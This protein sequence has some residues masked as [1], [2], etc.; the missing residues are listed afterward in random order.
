MRISSQNGQVVSIFGVVATIAFVGS[1]VGPLLVPIQ[2]EFDVNFAALTAI[3]A[4]PSL[5]RVV[6]TPL[7]GQ[8]VDRVS[9]RLLVA[10][11]GTLLALGTLAAAM[12]PGLWALLGA[13]SAVGAASSFIENASIAHL[14]RLASP[15]ARGRTVSRGMSGF[16]FGMLVSPLLAGLLAVTVG[17]RAAFVLAAAVALL[18]AFAA[19]LLLRDIP[20]AISTGGQQPSR[21]R[22]G[23]SLRTIAGVV[24][25]GALL[26][27]GASTLRMVALPLYGGVSL[28]LDPAAVGLVLTLLSIVRAATSLVGGQ[29]M[30]RAGRRVII[31]AA[32]LMNL[33]AASLILL[34]AHGAWLAIA[35]LSFALGGLGATSPIVLLADRVPIHRIG[36]SV[37]ALQGAAG[38]TGLMLPLMGGVLMDANGVVALALLLVP[39]FAVALVVGVA[40]TRH[41]ISRRGTS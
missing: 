27:A 2:T 1:V 33:V 26:W 41:P 14:V 15:S 11:S 31:I 7:A 18:G 4:L 23:E 6:F 5:S 9:I 37:A 13:V 35:T 19:A 38:A 17:W 39:V 34:P 29:L 24:T 28:E 3:V 36:R 16:Q 10:G 21:D 32:V 20:S 30:D 8:L 12:A 22:T 25:F 40:V